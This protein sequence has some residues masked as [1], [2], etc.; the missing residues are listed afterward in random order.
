METHSQPRPLQDPR[1]LPPI[2]CKLA[3]TWNRSHTWTLPKGRWQPDLLPAR[4]GALMA[5]RWS[6]SSVGV[7]KPMALGTRS[8]D[9]W[10]V[11]S[12]DGLA[13]RTSRSPAM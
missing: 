7:L 5:C 12:I 11:R 10:T 13:D 9:W 4:R 1:R 8:R 2:T 3:G 6:A